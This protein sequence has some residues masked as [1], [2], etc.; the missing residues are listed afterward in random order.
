MTGFLLQI[1]IGK[2]VTRL[3]D[4][5]IDEPS[6]AMKISHNNTEFIAWGDPVLEGDLSQILND[7]LTPES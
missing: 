7:D 3:N 1:Q 4:L 5:L 6:P 2:K